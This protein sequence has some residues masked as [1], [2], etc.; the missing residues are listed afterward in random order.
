MSQERR[1]TLSG[2]LFVCLRTD[3]FLIEYGVPWLD[4][5]LLICV[6]SRPEEG[7]TNI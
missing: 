3:G 2:I 5:L 7:D 1:P 6:D 4:L